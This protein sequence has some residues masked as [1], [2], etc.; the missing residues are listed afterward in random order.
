[1]NEDDPCPYAKSEMTP[2]VLADGAVCWAF[3]KNDEPICVGCELTPAQLGL[4]RP[5][6]WDEVK[7]KAAATRMR[8]ELKADHRRKRG[9]W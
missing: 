7:K 6:G 4:P 9:R 3:G 5:A 2:C 8:E 1:M